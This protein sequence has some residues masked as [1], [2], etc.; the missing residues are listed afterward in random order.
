MVQKNKKKTELNLDQLKALG[1]TRDPVSED[2]IEEI[3]GSDLLGGKS[4]DGQDDV[5][6]GNV[7]QNWPTLGQSN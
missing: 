7:C 2:S 4:R 5:V 1:I 6:S 3:D